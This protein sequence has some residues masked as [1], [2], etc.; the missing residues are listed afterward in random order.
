MDDEI[1]GVDDD[2]AGFVG[3]FQFLQCYF[4]GFLKWG[5]TKTTGFNT[6]IWMIRGH[7]HLR[8]LPLSSIFSQ[9]VDF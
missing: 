8:K 9:P 5:I 4:G 6:M 2:L 1:F 3:S 7:P